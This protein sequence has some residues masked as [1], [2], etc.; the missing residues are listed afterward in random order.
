M[1]A[2]PLFRL[3]DRRGAGHRPPEPISFTCGDESRSNYCK[4]ALKAKLVTASLA[5][6]KD[7]SVDAAVAPVLS[8]P[9]F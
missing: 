8:E 3:E 4:L 9:D 6:A 7:T 2:F 1:C 5:A